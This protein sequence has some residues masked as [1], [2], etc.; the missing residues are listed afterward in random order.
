MYI[1]IENSSRDN[2]SPNY[3]VLGT[4]KTRRKAEKAI[5]ENA[6][7]CVTD[8][9]IGTEPNRNWGSDCIIAKIESVVRPAPYAPRVMIDLITQGGE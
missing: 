6:L 5:I 7:E 9:D 4:Y 1:V 3:E 8:E 2:D